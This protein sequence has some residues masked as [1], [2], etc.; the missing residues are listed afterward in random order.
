MALFAGL[1]LTACDKADL[2]TQYKDGTAPALTLSSSNIAPAPA[3]SNKVVLTLTWSN[4]AYATDSGKVKY[5][6]EIDSAGKNFSNPLSKT[7]T[8]T[9]SV[10]FT[11]KELNTFLVNKGY[12]FNKPVTMQ[13]RVVSSYS[14][15]NERLPSSAV[16]LTMTPYKVPPKVELPASGKLYIIG[17]ATQIGWT[18]GGLAPTQE[19]A[20]LDETTFAGIFYLSA[21]QSYLLLPVNGSWDAK[22][23]AIGANNTNNPSGDEFKSGGG[24]LLAPA[25]SGWYRV[26]VDFQS[27]KFSVTPYTGTLPSGDLYIVGDATPGGWNNPVPVPSQKFTRV[28]SSVWEITLPLEG[29]KEF[30]VLPSNGEWNKKYAVKD[31]SIAG[32]DSGGEF[33]YHQDG[34]PAPDDFQKNFKAPATQGTYKITLN[35]AAPTTTPNASG[36]FTIQ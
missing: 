3:D 1:L 10:S 8:G 35:F 20:R 24:D 11:A 33:G 18:N 7:L 22:Y 13:A 4:P 15:N 16:T 19:L 26:V 5:V 2:L 17:G 23:G 21:G 31:N 12:A 32:I 14:N 30:L 27:G 6:V 9:R 36:R 25:T 29:G 28:N 34:Q